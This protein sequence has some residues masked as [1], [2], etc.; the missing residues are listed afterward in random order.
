MPVVHL[1]RHGH[2]HNPDKVLYGR[3]P[4][5]RLSETGHAM[6]QAVADDLVE[7]GT[8]VGQVVASPLLRAQETARPLAEAFQLDIVTDD[9]LIEA[10]N[11][12]EGRPLQSGAADFMHPRNWWL[13]RNPFTPSWGEPYVEQRDRMW[14]AI[15][16]AAGANPDSDT[17][18][19]S[20]QLP[21]WVARLAFEKRSYLHDPRSRQ[22]G[23]ASL[24]S[25]TI[26][27]GEPVAMAYREPARHIEVPA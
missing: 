23:L 14:A 9:R 17:V 1:L 4:E 19:V 27:D 8:R 25:F 11:A 20:H 13:L 26:E 2:V 18:M 22:C 12:Y 10:L 7:I 3:L 6:A 15:R 16:D 21:I 24:T 5:F